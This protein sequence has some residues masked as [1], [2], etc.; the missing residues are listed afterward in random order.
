MSGPAKRVVIIGGGF[1]SYYAAQEL[2]KHAGRY[3]DVT[4]ISFTNF[5][6]FTPMLHEIAASDLEPTDIIVSLKRV[7]PRIHVLTAEAVGL[8]VEKRTVDMVHGPN[9]HRHQIGYDYLVLGPGSISNYFDLPGV[10]ENSI[11]MKTLD[12]AFYLRNH[13]VQQL[14]SA[15]LD[16]E[17][18]NPGN[19]NFVVCGGGFAG[20][21][22]VGAMTDFLEEAASRYPDLR[23]RKIRTVLLHGGDKLLPELGGSLGAY[24]QTKLC[25]RGVEVLMNSSVTGYI[26]GCVVYR[27]AA[28]EHE[29]PAKTLV[30][31]AGVRP[32]PLIEQLPVK[33][34]KSRLLTNP[35]LDLPDH[36]EIFAVGDCAAVPH[37]DKPGTFYGP[38]AQNALRQGIAAA[39]NLLARHTGKQM[40]PF[41]YRE[42]GQLA[43]IGQRDGVANLMGIRFSG[44]IA[45]WFWRTVYLYKLPSLSKKVRVLTNW[46]FDLFLPKDPIEFHF[47]RIPLMD[48]PFAAEPEARTAAEQ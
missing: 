38:T 7:L 37:P 22:T 28:G 29:I 1:A 27:D 34:E 18:E 2:Q 25:G 13:I 15:N 3:F 11:T 39:R 23:G 21:E 20:V 33:K 47:P 36:P 5:L 40:S 32:S 48:R 24:A 9:R 10:E 46:T 26:N 30:W 43:A 8:D 4:L 42:L 17:T 45:W 19:L 31:T 12:D 16:A 44:P 14:E 35:T 41:R 6:L